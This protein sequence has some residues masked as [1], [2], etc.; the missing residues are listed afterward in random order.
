MARHIEED[1]EGL[2]GIGDGGRT[3]KKNS[4]AAF[5]GGCIGVSVEE[6]ECNSLG[7]MIGGSGAGTANSNSEGNLAVYQ[8]ADDLFSDVSRGSCDKDHFVPCRPTAGS[9]VC[10]ND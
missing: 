2:L 5:Y 8:M 9:S 7:S 3:K 4:L 1:V 6:I 10:P